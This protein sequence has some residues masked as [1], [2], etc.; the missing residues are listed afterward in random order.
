V[1][2]AP[3]CGW[4]AKAIISA[5]EKNIGIA[6][7][8]CFEADVVALAVYDL[9]QERQAVRETPADLLQ[10][11]AERKPEAARDKYW[12]KAPNQLSNRLKEA[13][14]ALEAK[15]VSVKFGRPGGIRTIELQKAA[16][17]DIS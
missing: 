7:Q 8:A 1:A 3:A 2:A 11:L 17:G 14:P 9:M 16:T 10:L 15:G 6:A 5:Y 13:A 12:P 4:E